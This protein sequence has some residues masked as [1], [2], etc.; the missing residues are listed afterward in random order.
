MKAKV[1]DFEYKKLKLSRVYEIKTPFKHFLMENK[2]S[3][4]KNQDEIEVDIHLKIISKPFI[5]F[6]ENQEVVLKYPFIKG[7]LER[8]P[9]VSI[10][11]IHN[12]LTKANIAFKLIDFLWEVIHFLV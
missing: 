7:V 11:L 12:S 2:N 8:T 4:V 1:D 3:K 6:L 5:E 10:N 9:L